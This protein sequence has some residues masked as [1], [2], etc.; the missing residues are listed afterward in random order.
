[1]LVNFLYVILAVSCAACLYLVIQAVMLGDSGSAWLFGAFAFLLGLFPANAIVK[2]LEQRIPFFNRMQ[3]TEGRDPT[4]KG[5]RFVPHWFLMTALVV[6]GLLFLAVVVLP[7][8][9]K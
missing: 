8:L 9:L 1:M 6:S 4:L 2:L 7:R 3:R 5:T